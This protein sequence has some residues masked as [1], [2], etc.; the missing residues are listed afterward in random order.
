MVTLSSS[1]KTFIKLLWLSPDHQT[2]NEID[3]ISIISRWCSSLQDVK[4]YRGADCGSD[5]F[6]HIAKMPL[7]FKRL[8]QAE[9][10]MIFDTTKLKDTNTKIRYQLKVRSRFASLEETNNIEV[11][12]S[13]FKDVV[14]TA[15]DSIIGRR[16]STRKEQWILS[17]SWTL[18]VERKKVK[19]IRDQAVSDNMTAILGRKYNDLNKAVKNSCKRDKKQWIETKCQEAE[20]AA[21]KLMLVLFTKLPET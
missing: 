1:I 4:V 11:R 12:W 18:I 15:A 3:Y 19:L 8:K 14:H 7:K 10:Q 21:A 20:H 6:L 13:N 16:R 9:K 17:E 2:K 5:H